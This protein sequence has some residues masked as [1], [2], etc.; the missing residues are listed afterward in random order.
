VI[1]KAESLTTRGGCSDPS[2]MVR[3]RNVGQVVH[4]GVVV[5]HLSGEPILDYVVCLASPW[6]STL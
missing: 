3:A 5:G 2:G 6:P 4:N 1:L